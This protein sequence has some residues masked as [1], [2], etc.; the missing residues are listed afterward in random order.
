[1][2][3]ITKPHKIDFC[4]LTDFYQMT[5]REQ[6]IID[7]IQANPLIAQQELAELI[8]ISRSAIATH[9]TNLTAKGVIKG[10]GYVV[11]HERFSVVIGGANMDIVGAP[12]SAI[13]PFTSNP[14]TVS[15]SPGGVARNIAEN[16]ARLNNKCYLIAAIGNDNHGQQLID[17]TQRAGVDTSHVLTIEDANTS[18]YLS[19]VDDSGEMQLAVADMAI[20]EQLTPQRLKRHLPLLKQASCIVIDTN[21]SEALI[22]FLFTSLPNTDFF[23]DT[24][25]IAKVD[26]IRHFL[27]FIHSLKPNI[28]EAQHLSG[29]TIEDFSRLPELA[30][31]FHDQGV[32][33]IYLSLGKDGLFFSNSTTQQHITLPASIVTNVNGAGDAMTAALAHCHLSN[34]TPLESC[35][36]AL[37]AANLTLASTR[38]NNPELSQTSVN[39]LLKET[40]CS[41]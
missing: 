11:A 6:Q 31:W 18:S 41:H 40:S 9:I 16:M 2:I 13:L 5:N 26:K 12:N 3:F 32:K 36:F 22:E 24:V 23:V 17:T 29:I 37:A 21:I 14:G 19:I 34:K 8:G 30:N 15:S 35:L 10:R 28:L 38:T 1:L 20:V 33:N 27:P 25:S 4:P 39:K 7:A